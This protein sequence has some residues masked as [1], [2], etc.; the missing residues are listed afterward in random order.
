LARPA[1]PSGARSLADSRLGEFSL[2]VIG[3][4]LPASV[5]RSFNYLKV[6]DNTR[7]STPSDKGGTCFEPF[8][9]HLA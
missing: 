4:C 5:R 2:S 3:I 1:I 7:I 6:R 9:A 8:G